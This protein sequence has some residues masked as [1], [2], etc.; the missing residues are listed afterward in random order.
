[1]A[2]TIGNSLNFPSYVSAKTPE[3]LV[4]E[5]MKNNLKHHKE[6]A[7]RDIQFVKDTWYA[8]FDLDHSST[9][10]GLKEVKE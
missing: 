2:L 6:F 7:Y 9:L 1:M 5:F 4:A 8:W 10:R 3:L